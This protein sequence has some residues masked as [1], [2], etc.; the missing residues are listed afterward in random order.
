MRIVSL[1]ALF[2]FQPNVSI[3]TIIRGL[4]LEWFHSTADAKQVAVKE[5]LKDTLETGAKFLCFAHHQV[6]LY[7]DILNSIYCIGIYKP[8]FLPVC[9]PQSMLTMIEALLQEKKVGYVKIDG[10]TSR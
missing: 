7:I 3:F 6:Y 4:L 9:S 8:Y 5:Y 10:S 1:A 2:N